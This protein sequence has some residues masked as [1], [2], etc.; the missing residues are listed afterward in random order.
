MIACFPVYRTYITPDG[1]ASDAGRKVID[2]AIAMARRRNPA[3]ERSVFDF[4]REVLLPPPNNAHPVDE[5]A[6]REFV[7]KFQQCSGP[8]TAKGVEDTAFYNYHRLIALNEV[9]G[10]PGVFGAA[11]ET[12][13]AQ[14]SA[15]L[16]EFP[17]SMLATSTHDTKRSEDVRARI[18]ALSELPREWAQTVK[19]WQTANRKYLRMVDGEVAPSPNEEYLLYQTLVGSWPLELLEG[20]PAEAAEQYPFDTYVQRIQAYMIK[21]LHEAKVNSSWID[22]NQAWDQAVTEFVAAILE[23]KKNA[24]FLTPFVPFVTRIAQLGAINSL[25]QLVLKSTA[26]GVPDFYQGNELWDFSLVDPDNRRPVD[27]EHRRR[28]LEGLGEQPAASELLGSWT[29]GR[30]KMFVTRTLL[31][32]RRAQ[33]SLFQNGSYEPVPVSGEFAGSVI[34]FQRVEGNSKLLVCVPRLSARIGFPPVGD[35][36]RDTALQAGGTWKNVFTGAE[37]QGEEMKVGNLLREFPV[38]VFT[39]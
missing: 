18:A 25:T 27:Y 38:G 7:M 1:V 20:A 17:H 33:P 23:R 24:R 14:N 35:L 37:L 6:R 15:R 21:A 16:A 34:A 39:G 26:P 5:E 11:L 32:L 12:F 10:E 29:D 28:V 19:R 22:P 36:W 30:V 13:H 31:H 9:G 4:L 2:R 3:I 8:I